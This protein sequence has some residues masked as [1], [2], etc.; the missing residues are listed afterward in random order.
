MNYIYI[1][2]D[3]IFQSCGSYRD[4]LDWWLLLTRRLLHQGSHHFES[5]TVS[6]IKNQKNANPTKNQGRTH[7]L[8]KG[9]QF[10][11]P[12]WDPSCY[13]CYKHGDKSWIRKGPDC[14]LPEHMSS[15]LVFSR[16]S[17]FL[18][19]CVVFCRSLFVLLPFFFLPLHYLSLDLRLLIG[20]LVSSNFS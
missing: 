7:V 2:A 4:F 8:R 16:V 5:F 15:P 3:L 20:P 13:S 10:L 18:V 14:D 17:V 11:L 19:F 9:R 6:T 12:M 1:S